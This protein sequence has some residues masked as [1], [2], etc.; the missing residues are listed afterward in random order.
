MQ[1]GQALYRKYRSKGLDEVVGQEHI[2]RTLEHALKTGRINHAYLFTGPRGVGK[3][4][5]ARILAHQINKLPYTDD[6]THLDIIEID[7]A[8]NR[9]IDEIRD[10]RDKAHIAPTSAPYKV[11]IIDEVHML[12]KEAFNALLKTLEEPPQHVV[13]ILATTEAH[14]LP[15]TIVSRTQRFTFKP[16]APDKVVAHLRSIADQEGIA[17]TD[18]ALTL[19]A[20]HGEGS[21]RDSISLL[22]QASGHGGKVDVVYVQSLLGV[23]PAEAIDTLLDALVARDGAAVIQRLTQ[24]HEQGFQ[25]TQIAHQLSTA[26]RERLIASKAPSASDFNF[27]Q[28]LLEVPA[29]HNPKRFLDIILLEFALAN[30]QVAGSILTSKPAVSPKQPEAVTPVKAEP[31]SPTITQKPV[32]KKFEAG[33]PKS[34][35]ASISEKKQDSSTTVLSESIWPQILAEL[36]KKYNTL[37]GVVRMAEPTFNGNSLEMA[38]SFAFHRKRLSEAKNQ[39][40]LANIIKQIT[41]QSVSIICVDSQSAPASPPAAVEVVEN[42]A[43]IA[44][45][46]E[47]S[48]KKPDISNISNIFGGAELLESE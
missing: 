22:D 39:Q 17:I 31:L 2:T 25:A 42:A 34:V 21:F 4:S 47:E 46:S 45:P 10:L 12:T 38:F 9:R 23:P 33:A 28:K 27:L 20:A 16:V 8:S 44:L 7:A 43:A 40:V 29:A 13:F 1:M 19:I 26:W 30:R 37:Y 35:P 15:E 3:T 5:V 41:G 32:S 11:Y 6:S 14:K 18:D 36:K 48:P 24:L